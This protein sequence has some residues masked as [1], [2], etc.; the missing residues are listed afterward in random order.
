VTGL[1]QIPNV[2]YDPRLVSSRV[3]T[4]A[5]IF[6]AF[7]ILTRNDKYVARIIDVMGTF[8]K[9]KLASNKAMLVLEVPQGF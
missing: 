3:M 4:Q 6:T 8:L 7:T 9:G 2:P 5:A 1:E